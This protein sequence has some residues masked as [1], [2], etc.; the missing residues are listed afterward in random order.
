MIGYLT[1]KPGALY[2]RLKCECDESGNLSG[3]I[4]SFPD[5]IRA[6]TGVKI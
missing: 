2:H 1:G 5:N 3:E 6:S 4:E